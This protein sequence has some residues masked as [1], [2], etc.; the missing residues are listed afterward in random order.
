MKKKE[1]KKNKKTV[2]NIF[3]AESCPCC[4]KLFD[5]SVQECDQRYNCDNN[6]VKT[7]LEISAVSENGF[8]VFAGLLVHYI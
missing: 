7:N 4:R 1:N 6:A 3:N 8:A 5:R 2:D